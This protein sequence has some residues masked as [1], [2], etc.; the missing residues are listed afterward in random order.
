MLGCS[1][2][3]FYGK[4]SGSL[5]QMCGMYP[6]PPLP[7]NLQSHL[8]WEVSYHAGQGLLPVHH[9]SDNTISPI[10]AQ[11]LEDFFFKIKVNLS[12]EG[13]G[14][15]N[16]GVGCILL[17][18]NQKTSHLF[19]APLW[20]VCLFSGR[21]G[22]SARANNSTLRVMDCTTGTLPAIPLKYRT[23]LWRNT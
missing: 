16:I 4:E 13:S 9:Y 17:N 2:H 19:L 20:T 22:T 15:C 23:S 3:I 18:Y 11:L 6:I 10:L 1:W 12:W 8:S 7:E 14:I 5:S 21:K